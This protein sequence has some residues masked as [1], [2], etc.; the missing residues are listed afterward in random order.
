MNGN[1][2]FNMNNLNW[3]VQREN[4]KMPLNWIEL[5]ASGVITKN[6]SYFFNTQRVKL[7]DAMKNVKKNREQFT[8]LIEIVRKYQIV[9]T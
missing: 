2:V 7:E 3:F 8:Q 4:G 5:T 9:L 1:V 6:N